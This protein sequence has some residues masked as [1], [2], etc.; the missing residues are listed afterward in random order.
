MDRILC[1]KALLNE[2]TGKEGVDVPTTTHEIGAASLK[3]IH[4][5]VTIYLVDDRGETS[6]MR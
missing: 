4:D 3:G 2:I 6:T 5:P 1:S